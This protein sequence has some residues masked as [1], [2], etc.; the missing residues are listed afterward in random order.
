MTDEKSLAVVNT[1]TSLFELGPKAVASRAT[2]IA[3]VLKS[4][5]EKQ[6]LFT[7][8]KG[9]K[10]V[11]VEGWQAIGTMVGIVPKERRV[12]ELEDGSY[13]A[14]VELIN[15]KT[16]LVVGGGSALCS[17]DEKRWGEA[18]KYARRSMAVTRA[19]G[20]SYRLTF[21]W[22]MSMAGYETT[23]EEEMP[24]SERL[25]PAFVNTYAQK[26]LDPSVTTQQFYTAAKATG[27]I[28]E[29]QKK[30]L[31]AIA[32]KNG[33]S[34]DQ[35][36]IVCNKLHQCDPANMSWKV[37]KDFVDIVEKK[38]FAAAMSELEEFSAAQVETPSIPEMDSIPF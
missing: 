11:R 28:S 3:N 29:P 1:E 7:D 20:K 6:N 16:G 23:P 38:S 18:D 26:P 12:T 34:G 36:N 32:G 22:V 21:G 15:V 19:V 9:K 24:Q 35:V 30:R 4:I 31:Y 10:Y 8:I 17:M 25:Q 13:V 27:G 37:Y 14:E 5:I 33:W 2:E